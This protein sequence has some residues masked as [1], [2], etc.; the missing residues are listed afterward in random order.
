MPFA[1]HETFSID[2]VGLTHTTHDGGV[3]TIVRGVQPFSVTVNVTELVRFKK[4]P[5]FD[6][7]VAPGTVI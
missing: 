6:V 1:L 5:T 2:N 4:L 3:T 7:T